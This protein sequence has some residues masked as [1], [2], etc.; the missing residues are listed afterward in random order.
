MEDL[1]K[2]QLG[3]RLNRAETAIGIGRRTIQ[4]LLA[5]E[6]VD[7]EA[8]EEHRA[9]VADSRLE[10]NELRRQL[11]REKSVEAVRSYRWVSRGS[12]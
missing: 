1:T 7:Y 2:E 8:I 12:E 11:E 6:P 4:A 3:K 10:R 5:E 9:V